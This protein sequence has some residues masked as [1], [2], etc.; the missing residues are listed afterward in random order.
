MADFIPRHQITVTIDLG[1]ICSVKRFAFGQLQVKT[2]GIYCSRYVYVSVSEDGNKFGTV[3]QNIDE[4]SVTS[5]EDKRVDNNIT[6]DKYYK[7]RYVKVV[8]SSDVF[9]YAD[10][11][12]VFGSKDPNLGVSVQP[13]AEPTYPDAF[14]SDGDGLR[15]I[16]LMYCGKYYN[17]SESSIGQSTEDK[18]LPYFAYV[19]KN[20]KP[21]D[22]MF[23][24][25]LFLPLNPA[26]D[27]SKGTEDCSFGKMT[28]WEAYLESAIGNKSN[29]VNIAVLN[30]IVGKYKAQLGLGADYKYPV[31]ISVPYIH[32]SDSIVFGSIDG[33]NDCSLKSREQSKNRKMV[34]RP[35]PDIV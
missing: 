21:L 10:E 11:I 3:G 35:C 5:A 22:T 24:G 33:E 25:M 1:E 31:Y 16:V 23:D 26:P 19:D 4:K 7:V 9:V 20:K 30:D 12:E 17:G 27:K 29:H 28:G 2:A 34:Y 8:F 32:L 15:N 14:P 6:F 13:D 18:L